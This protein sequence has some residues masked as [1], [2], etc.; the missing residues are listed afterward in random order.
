MNFEQR[1]AE[2]GE[3]GERPCSL[4]TGLLVSVGRA[5]ILEIARPGPSSGSLSP[6]ALCRHVVESAAG[7][8]G[9]REPGPSGGAPTLGAGARLV[10]CPPGGAPFCFSWRRGKQGFAGPPLDPGKNP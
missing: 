4:R 2:K 5:H 10:S 8:P 6:R 1:A 9:Q 3:R 7:N